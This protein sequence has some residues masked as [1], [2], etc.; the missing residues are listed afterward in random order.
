MINNDLDSIEESFVSITKLSNEAIKDLERWY[1]RQN[2]LVKCDISHEQRNQYFKYSKQLKNKN[3]VS[4]IAFYMAI[5]HFSD[6]MTLHLNKNK[7]M[8]LKNLEKSSDFAIKQFRKS[9]AKIKREKLI[10]LWSVI[11]K[12]KNEDFSFRDISKFLR[13]KHRFQVSHTYISQVWKE[14]ENEC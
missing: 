1:S 7:S 2:I 9:K 3:L 10:S 12:L 11:V 8:S 4:V 6:H 5:K 13:S 14:L